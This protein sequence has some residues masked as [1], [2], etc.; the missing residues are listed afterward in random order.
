MALRLPCST[1]IEIVKNLLS[2]SGDW[3]VYAYVEFQQ[4]W[5]VLSSPQ[6]FLRGTRLLAR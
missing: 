6:S 2:V 4:G 1:S 5:E 3:E